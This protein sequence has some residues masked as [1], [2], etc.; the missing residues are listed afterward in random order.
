LEDEESIDTPSLIWPTSS[1]CLG[2]FVSAL[3]SCVLLFLNGGVVM[4]ILNAL[5]DQNWT[6]FRDDQLSQFWVLIGPVILL[7]IQWRMIDYLRDHLAPRENPAIDP[8]R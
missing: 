3:V 8:D 7:I 5:D 6:L 2:V 4:A 1:G